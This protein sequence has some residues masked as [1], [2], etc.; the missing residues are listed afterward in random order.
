MRSRWS[1]LQG[2][3][4]GVGV[5]LGQSAGKRIGIS[6]EMC[7]GFI[8]LVFTRTRNRELDQRR[9]DWGEEQHQ[10]RPKSSSATTVTVAL[11]AAENHSPT[12]NLRDIGNCTR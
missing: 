7:S 5:E 11:V 4:F 12:R 9:G 2:Q 3:A 6:G 8:G 10:Q 1:G